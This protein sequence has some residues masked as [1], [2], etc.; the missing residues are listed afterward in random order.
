VGE[1]ESLRR[2]T[3]ACL[4]RGNTEDQA[5]GGTSGARPLIRVGIA[6]WKRI[7]WAPRR[8][9]QSSTRHNL[10]PAKPTL[11]SA[12]LDKVARFSRSF[13]TFSRSTPDLLGPAE[14]LRPCVAQPGH[15]LRSRSVPSLFLLG[16]LA[17]FSIGI[18]P[19]APTH[20]ISSCSLPP[21]SPT[22][23][24]EQ[25]LRGR[26][27]LQQRRPVSTRLP[28]GNSNPRGY[29][30]RQGRRPRKQR[31]D[32]QRC[33]SQ[34]LAS[35]RQMLVDTATSWSI[36]ARSGVLSRRSPTM[37]L[38]SSDLTSSLVV[39]QSAYPTPAPGCTPFRTQSQ[40]IL[41]HRCRPQPHEARHLGLRPQRRQGFYIR[42]R[43]R[44][45][46]D[47]RWHPGLLQGLGMGLDC[48]P[49]PR[50]ISQRARC[51]R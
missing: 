20:L 31:R 45:R 27:V 30:C 9:T 11:D 21:S 26:G 24:S 25:Y 39:S 42:L 50:R 44:F 37:G 15:L 12:R 51:R 5:E 1:R 33:S 6:Q 18:Q 4:A 16:P 23:L 49:L 34:M 8:T 41:P 3:V 32:V 22:S 10:L 46:R 47:G 36:G 29:R 40:D 19:R 28:S 48:F 14:H 2:A 7:C 43:P 17:A 35:T 13:L 38:P